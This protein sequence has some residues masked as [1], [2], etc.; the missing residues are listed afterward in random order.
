MPP[1]RKPAKR[2]GRKRRTATSLKIELQNK[3]NTRGYSKDIYSFETEFY[4]ET[5]HLSMQRV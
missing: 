2:K 4:S 3:R 5:I 1:K